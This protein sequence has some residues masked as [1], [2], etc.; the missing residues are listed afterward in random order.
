MATGRFA[1][2]KR[3]KNAGICS[4]ARGKGG[5]DSDKNRAA[6]TD[7]TGAGS[8]FMIRKVTIC[9][10]P[11]PNT[12]FLQSQP[13]TLPS[14]M[15]GSSTPQPWPPADHAGSLRIFS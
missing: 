12:L 2:S 6:S 9:L 1:S 3:H 4:G 7:N 13:Q 8:H 15:V 5:N 10:I 14:Q 11:A